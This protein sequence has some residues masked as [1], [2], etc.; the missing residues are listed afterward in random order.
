VIIRVTGPGGSFDELHVDGGTTSSLF[1][2]PQIA[3]FLPA[4]LPALRGANLYVIVN[5]QLGAASQATPIGTWDILKRGIAAGLRS[6]ELADL[7]IAVAFAERNA[8]TIRVTDI[9]GDYPFHGPLDLGPSAL[10]SL[11]G[12]GARCSAQGQVWA[13]PV[14][15]IEEAQRAQVAQSGGSTQCP[16]RRATGQAPAVGTLEV[17]ESAH[18][19]DPYSA[20]ALRP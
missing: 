3:G 20:S 12:Y 5:T 11:F 15:V 16:A 7:Q 1:I 18:A 14:E 4:R 8:M 10:K 6:G 17:Q 19:P 2:A 9:P 13:T